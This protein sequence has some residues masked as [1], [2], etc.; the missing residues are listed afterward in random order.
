LPH[1]RLQVPIL[2]ITAVLNLWVYGGTARYSLPDSANTGYLIAATL[3][4]SCVGFGMYLLVPYRPSPLWIEGVVAA[5]AMTP[6]AGFLALWLGEVL[7][8]SNFPVVVHL[9]LL[10][11]C[12]GLAG[13][14]MRA[15]GVWR[16]AALG[17]ALCFALI[18][19]DSMRFGRMLQA[20]TPAGGCLIF[21][22]QTAAFPLMALTVA[23]P[24]Y[25]LGDG[26]WLRWSFRSRGFV[27][28]SGPHDPQCPSP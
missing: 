4:L 7:S 2:L 26:K 12:L 18:T 15:H 20:G 17:M 11:W 5:L 28:G 9:G 13:L 16:S 24:V 6:P 21:G 3:G 1:R 25:W 8:G 22:D 19:L 27:S 10:A 14:G 23:K